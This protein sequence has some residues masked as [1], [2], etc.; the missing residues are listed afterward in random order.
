MSF[1]AIITSTDR[2]AITE[3][4]LSAFWAFAI[5]ARAFR[6]STLSTADTFYTLESSRAIEVVFAAQDRKA[7][8]IDTLVTLWAITIVGALLI[9]QSIEAFHATR[10]RF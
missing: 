1:W 2:I 4:A 9:A 8:S 5:F 6:R 10:A 3:V 7:K